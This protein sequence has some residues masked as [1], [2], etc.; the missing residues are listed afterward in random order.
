M[1]C[2]KCKRFP[3]PTSAFV[4]LS[5]SH[6]RHGTLYKCKY[7]SQF[8]EIIEESR[9]F[10]VLTDEEARSI[11]HIRGFLKEALVPQEA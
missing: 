9:T 5:I 11:Y 7:C 4:E 10:N 1:G 6:K 8:Y 2:E 3:A